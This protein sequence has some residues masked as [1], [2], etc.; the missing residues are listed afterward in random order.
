MLGLISSILA[1]CACAQVSPDTRPAIAAAQQ[2]VVAV[3]TAPASAPAAPISTQ[4]LNDLLGKL[5]HPRYAIREEATQQLCHL[6]AAYLPELLRRYRA[7]SRFEPK[8]RIR[9]AIEY[10]FFREQIIGRD[11]FLGIEVYSS[12]LSDLVDPATGKPTRGV[13]VRAVKPGFAAEHYGLRADDILIAFDNKDVPDDPNNLGSTQGFI[14]L[15]SGRP[16]GSVAPIR[17]IRPGPREAVS[18]EAPRE[19]AKTFEG[20][21]FFVFTDLAATPGMLAL[22]VDRDSQAWQIGLRSG[23]LVRTLNGQRLGSG[24]IGFQNVLA[25]TA[26]GAKMAMEISRPQSLS[27]TIKLG[28]RPPEYISDP[29]DRAEAQARFAQWWQDQGG[30]DVA[31]DADQRPRRNPFN[32][33]QQPAQ[34]SPDN[35]IIP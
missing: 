25:Q 6:D 29:K 35:S 15:V 26:P 30:E 24:L 34:V 31:K 21:K 19:P 5:S 20:A 12:V 3:S 14:Q 8:R 27:L 28:S 11:G 22:S 13:M 16:P 23:D 2:S 4:R 33:F 9:Y 32:P 18:F 7:E 17:L 1:L 10:V